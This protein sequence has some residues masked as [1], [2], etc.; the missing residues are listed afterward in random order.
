MANVNFRK[1]LRAGL[2]ATYAEGTFYVTTDERAIYLD[3]SD[4]ARIRLG[5]FQEFATIDALTA[6]T[7]PSTTAL[8]YVTD[9]NCLAK[10]NG[11]EYVQ[12]NKDTGMTS[13]EVVGDGNAVTAAVYSADG[14]K[15]TLTKGATYMTAGDVDSKIS[16]AIGTL[17]N[18]TEGNAYANVK[19][20]VDA[21][22]SGIAT[23][24]AL[25]ELQNRVATAEGEIDALQAAVGETGDVTKAIAAAQ[26]A[27]DDAAAAAE[28]AQATA[29]SKATMAEVEAKDY[30]TKTEAQS[31]ANAKDA[32]IAAAQAAA[33]AAQSTANSKAT[34]DEVN[35]AIAGAGHAV[36][37]EVDKSISDL[38][39]AYKAADG[40]LDTKLQGNI[41]KKVD[42]TAYDSKVAELAGADTTLQGNIDAAVEA[43]EGADEAQVARIEALE[44]TITGLSGAMHFKGVETALP[45][46]DALANYAD[47]DVIVVGEKEYVFNDGAFVEFGDVS[48]EGDRISA[49]EN[50]VGDAE[51]GL[52]KGVADNNAAIEAEAE[53][54]GNAE[55]A[56]SGRIDAL[57]AIDHDHTNKAVLDGI[58]A[59]KVA[60]WDG[61]QAAAEATASAALSAAKTE[62]E[63]KI[64]AASGAAAAAQSK[65]DEA[66]ELAGTKAT[67]AEVE[68]KGYATETKAGELATAAE[69]AAKAH[70]DGLNTAMNTRVAVLEAID[71]DAYKGYAD[72]AEADAV[73]SANAYA[74]SLATNYDAAG[75]AATAETNAKAYADSLVMTWGSF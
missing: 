46:G 19:A 55:S 53:R 2:P 43:L 69:N 7:N 44:D 9:I 56:L 37:S 71:H 64:T 36:K 38:D 40:A 42:Q 47:G 52:V 57:E 24:A 74:D 61:A 51:S 35:A 22:T 21:K 15:L 49:L 68:A 62:L 14:R 72:Q 29:D 59:E 58:T 10:W 13:V 6:N 41:D 4:S 20:Y 63:G 8:Y 70:A 65:A 33:E 67:M 16:T 31:Y 3:V 17:G 11:S 39:A 48:A 73:T 25:G 32:A 60:A 28:A 66:Y 1:G 27:A 34:M 23:D 30:A 12:I 54:A 50:T 45:E 75:S 26:K 5:D 18:D